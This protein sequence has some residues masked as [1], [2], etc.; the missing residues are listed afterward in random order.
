MDLLVISCKKVVVHILF[1]S[2]KSEPSKES[3]SD[4][5]RTQK[6]SSYDFSPLITGTRT[7]PFTSMGSP[8]AALSF[9]RHGFRSTLSAC[10]NPS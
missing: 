9:L 5:S 2:R 7:T 4:S 1:A 3:A 10:F 6:P 8:F